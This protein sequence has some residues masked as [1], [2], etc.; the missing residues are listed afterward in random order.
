MPSPDVVELTRALIRFDTV[1]PPGR[2]EECA[3]FLAGLLAEAGFAVR[4]D[5]FGP[6]RVNLLATLAGAADAPSLCLTGHLDTVPLG[7]ARWERDPFAGEI[8]DG[9]LYGRGSCDMK[10]GVAAMV[11][12]ALAAAASPAR[13][14]GLV[15]LLTG[16]EETGCEGARHFA[17]R[18][19]AGPVGAVLVAEPTDNRPLVAHKGVLWLQATTSGT[20]AHG[21]M[22]EHGDNAVYK[23][24]RAAVALEAYDFAVAPH[25]LL[26]RPTLN[27]GTIHG[28]TNTNSVPDRAV[29]TVD[30][31][32]VP[33][34]SHAEVRDRLAARLGPGVGLEPLVDLPGIH[35]DP[36]DG[37][38]RQVAAAAAEVTGET[39]PAGGASYF[40]DASVLV[41]AFGTPPTVVLGPGDPA[42]AHR[43]DE[44]CSLE[45][46]R[47]AVEIYTSLVRDWRSGRHGAADAAPARRR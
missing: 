44:W 42:V 16:G 8:A 14:G 27:L 3:R 10:G 37:W 28:G 12:A 34:Q 26:G 4:L 30:I 17:E 36:G 40:T 35:T 31:R 45:R 11:V 22:P 21:S 13:N 24:A 19:G 32:T 43:T 33:G 29:M 6:G 38:V 23:A 25:P 46:L 9:R 2:E 41:P 20:T 15:L 47:Q 18:G 1:N 7:G 39:V 5:P